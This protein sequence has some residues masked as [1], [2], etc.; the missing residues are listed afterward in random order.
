MSSCG[1]FALGGGA[2]TE[3]VT[4][5]ITGT[6]TGTGNRLLDE[7][8]RGYYR[9]TDDDVITQ[10]HID[11]IT[12]LEI[13]L[14]NINIFTKDSANELPPSQY[15]EDTDFFDGVYIDYIVNGEEVNAFPKIIDAVRFK[16]VYLRSVNDYYYGNETLTEDEAAHLSDNENPYIT[17]KAA[18]KLNAFYAVKDP[19]DPSLD[20]QTVELLKLKYPFITDYA[21][22]VF[23]PYVSSREQYFITSYYYSAGLFKNYTI[24]EGYFDASALKVF[25]NLR[26]VTYSGVK[27]VNESLPVG[28]TSQYYDYQYNNIFTDWDTQNGTII[29]TGAAG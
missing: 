26:T 14:S 28:A 12:T 24:P 11:G 19:N 9:L 27:P 17:T 22:A 29:T 20:K 16:E 23:D 18:W 25:T 8:L 5:A 13:R 15:F 21:V 3:T 1:A 6:I 7:A 2:V 10:E 4:E